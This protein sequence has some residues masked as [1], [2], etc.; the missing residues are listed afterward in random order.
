MKI[1]HLV[2][3]E[4][5]GV[6]SFVPFYLRPLGHRKDVH[7]LSPTENNYFSNAKNS[8]LYLKTLI[9]I[10]YV[11]RKSNCVNCWRRLWIIAEKMSTSNFKY[12]QIRKFENR[13]I[14]KLF[15]W[16]SSLAG[17][18]IIWGH[19][20]WCLLLPSYNFVHDIS[21]CVNTMRTFFICIGI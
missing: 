17:V 15:G 18:Q 16:L 14:W 13:L 5:G 1:F 21:L 3:F 6:F 4:A 8:D 9:S 7:V 12:Q 19:L 11:L 2:V 10:W 20:L